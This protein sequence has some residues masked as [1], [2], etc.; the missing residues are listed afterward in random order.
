MRLVTDR[1]AARCARHT[2]LP[3]TK[4]D[5]FDKTFESHFRFRLIRV[6][7]VDLDLSPH[8]GPQHLRESGAHRSGWDFH[9]ARKRFRHEDLGG[10]GLTIIGFPQIADVPMRH[11][12]TRDLRALLGQRLAPPVRVYVDARTKMDECQRTLRYPQ[13]TDQRPLALPRL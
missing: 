13:T 9:L 4:L 11:A 10:V 6:S 2:L 5:E 12:M 1:Y 7:T 8:D 3:L